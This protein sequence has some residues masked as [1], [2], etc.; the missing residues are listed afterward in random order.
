MAWIRY[1]LYFL[2]VALVT[3]LLTQIEVA[4]PGS[5]KLHVVLQEGDKFGTS[6]FS[7]IEFIQPLILIVCALMMLWV[8]Q[9]CPSQRP[10]ALPFAGLAVAFWLRELH[11]FLDRYLI[12][13]LWQ[14]LV[15]IVGALVIVYTYRQQ[16]RL[17]V[18]LARLWPSP[19]LAFLF[20]GA[21][22]LFAFVQFVGHEPLWQAMLGED[23]RRIVKLAVE[24]FIE[25]MGYFLF[26]IGTIEYAYQARAI[27]F[28][29]PQHAVQR[30][31]EKR[32]HDQ[33]GEY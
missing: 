2:G 10:I 17:Q 8:A 16:R 29:E 9:Y 33:E 23:Y 1:L 30:L 25:L 5:L 13:N 11:Y 18:A 15:A 14:V 28:R 7:P 4:F 31:R 32:R 19:A 24:E 20:A 6:E 21:L 3:G 26:L 12:D 27:A 22:V